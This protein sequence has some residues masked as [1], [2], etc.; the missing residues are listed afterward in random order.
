MQGG[1]TRG[2]RMD[3]TLLLLPPLAYAC[4][5][6]EMYEILEI[7]GL[8]GMKGCLQSSQKVGASGRRAC[9]AAISHSKATGDGAGRLGGPRA[10]R[11]AQGTGW[12]A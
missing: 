2:R 11:R 9:A 4:V 8:P 7:C 6:A 1:C 12:G 3:A 5:C 10:G